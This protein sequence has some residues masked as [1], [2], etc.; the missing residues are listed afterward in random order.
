MILTKGHC[1]PPWGPG[2]EGWDGTDPGV[3]DIGSEAL[4][5]PLVSRTGH[6]TKNGRN[7]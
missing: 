3:P 2:S 7:N 1:Q 5:L 6:S 4:G